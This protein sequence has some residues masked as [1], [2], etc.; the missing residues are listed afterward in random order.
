MKAV[1][2]RVTE[3]GGRDAT[4]RHIPPKLALAVGMPSAA[5]PKGWRWTKLTDIARLESGHTP[6]RRHPEWWGGSIPW[7]GIQDARANDEGRIVDTQEK[8]NALGIEHS[9][10]RVLPTNTV[11]LSRTASVGY[12]VVLGR[13]MATSQDFVNWV[14]SA[15]LDHDFLKYLLIAEGDDLLR[16]ASGSVHQTIYFP[17]A[18][19]FHI[20]H[21]VLDEQRRIVHVLD[22][23]F[24]SIATAK[25]NTERNIQNPR[26]AF[27][28]YLESVV[29]RRGAGWTT[30]PLG[31]LC[32]FQRGLTYAKPDEVLSSRNVVLRA[33]NINLETNALDFRDLRYIRDSVVVPDCKKIKGGSLIICTA[34]G[35]KS[36]LGKV[37]HVDEDSDFAFGG[38]MGMLTPRNGLISKYLFHLM[39]S[40]SY[41]HFIDRLSDGANINNLTFDSLGRFLLPYPP[42][43]E[44]RRIARLCDSLREET[45][46]LAASYARK[47]TVLDELR[48]SVLHE[49]FIGAL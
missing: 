31:A 10:A 26:E 1:A 25:A 15:Q 22:R 34:S 32:E 20:C 12:V 27:E 23:A 18:K 8:T 42:T 40:A 43:D 17:E 9:S 11:C 24:E 36:H 16:F 35:S 41:K 14:C 29:T 30:Q 21:P 47:L 6:S 3:T 28:S 39:T 4:T 48:R 38:F 49:A 19:A 46:R 7:M 37:A 2:A 45:R 33:N 44:Q 13:P 5:P